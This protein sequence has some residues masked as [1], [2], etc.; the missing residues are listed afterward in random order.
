VEEVLA[1]PF[2]AKI[3]MEALRDRKL[4]APFIPKVHDLD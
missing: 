3:D 2:F 1:H 4:A